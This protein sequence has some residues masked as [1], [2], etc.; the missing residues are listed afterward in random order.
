M[1]KLFS[2]IAVCSNKMMQPIAIVGPQSPFKN[3]AVID[4]C[5][6]SKIPY[7]QATWQ[8]PEIEY[9][10]DTT[11]DNS[12]ESDGQEDTVDYKK[13]IIN[14]YPDSD[15]ISTAHAALLKYY[16]WENFAALYEDEHGIFRFLPLDGRSDNESGE[17]MLFHFSV[18]FRFNAYTEN[19]SRI[20]RPVSSDYKKT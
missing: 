11:V 16:K 7:L 12:T 19:F 18:F 9:F 13:I 4:Q 14:F 3:T 8:P 2:S 15:E 5:I 17:L 10:E 20:H 1:G 6:I